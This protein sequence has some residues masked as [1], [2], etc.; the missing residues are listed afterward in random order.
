M[1][2]PDE[3]LLGW[4]CIM[5]MNFSHDMAITLPPVVQRQLAA[6]GWLEVS[7]KPDYDGNHYAH[8]TEAGAAASDLAIA[9]IAF[10]AA[11]V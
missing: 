2:L 7:E 6:R 3:K 8:V 9:T 11:S 10:P 4:L 5:R 1:N